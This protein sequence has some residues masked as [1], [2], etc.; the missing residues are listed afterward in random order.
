[1]ATTFGLGTEP[2]T[3]WR[4]LMRRWRRQSRAGSAIVEFAMI[5]PVF[6]LLLFSIMEV[7][8]IFYAQST[9]QFAAEDVGR[10]VRTGQAQNGAMT[11]G[12]VRNRVCTDIQPLIPCSGDLFVDI[13]A[14]PNFTGIIFSPPVDPNG[15]MIPLNNFQL[16]QACSVVL[17]RVFYQWPV[18]TPTLTPFL[19]NLANKKHLLYAASAFRNEPYST[20]I[21]GC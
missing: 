13:E 12:Q 21:S 3:R 17:V 15:N 8:I 2:G 9:L 20:G 1:M 7:G 18:F 19:S 10:L 6:F 16:G 11:Q 5:A 14:F 4:A